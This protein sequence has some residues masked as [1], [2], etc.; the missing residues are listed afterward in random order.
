[1]V[2]ILLP[3]KINKMKRIVKIVNN[4]SQHLWVLILCCFK[5]FIHIN[6]LIFITSL[7]SH[8]TNEETGSERLSMLFKVTQH[9]RGK[10]SD[11]RALALCQSEW[12][13]TSQKTPTWFIQVLACEDKEKQ[14]SV[15]ITGDWSGVISQIYEHFTISKPSCYMTTHTIFME[16]Q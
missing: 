10:P 3:L 16:V 11:S 6:S 1:M 9:G 7:W 13:G 2:L 8:Y 14:P 5:C 4:K 15:W 12:K